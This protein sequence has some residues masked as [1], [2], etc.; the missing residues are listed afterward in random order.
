[1]PLGD[2]V[3]AIRL[4]KY[5]GQYFAD[6]PINKTYHSI[7]RRYRYLQSRSRDSQPEHNWQDK[8][9]RPLLF[10]SD[11]PVTV[12]P[13]HYSNTSQLECASTNWN[14]LRNV[15]DKEETCEREEKGMR[16]RG[17]DKSPPFKAA[18]MSRGKQFSALEHTHAYLHILRSFS[19]YRKAFACPSLKLAGVDESPLHGD[20]TDE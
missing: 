20:K 9:T 8:E 19:L 6:V 10:C 12:K 18:G 15:K 13:T 5:R 14:I 1:M 11:M 4:D 17:R 16:K 2:T 7:W 3:N